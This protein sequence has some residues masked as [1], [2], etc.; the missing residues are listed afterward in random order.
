MN[1]EQK[2]TFWQG[3]LLAI[4]GGFIASLFASLWIE[5]FFDAASDFVWGEYLLWG[6]FAIVFFCFLFVLWK[7]NS[8]I[9]KANNIKRGRPKKSKK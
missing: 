2:Q 5:L 4:L 8:M 6:T 1:K 9:K 7:V 3:A